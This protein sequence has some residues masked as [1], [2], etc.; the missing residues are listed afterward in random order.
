M[1]VL[2]SEKRPLISLNNEP[3]WRESATASFVCSFTRSF[4]LYCNDSNHLAS[5]FDISVSH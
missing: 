3:V 5:P 1:D 4:P 2:I